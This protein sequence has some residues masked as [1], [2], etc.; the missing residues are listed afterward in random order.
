MP[1]PATHAAVGVLLGAYSRRG[2]LLCLVTTIFAVLPDIDVIL[3]IHR[4]PTHSLIIPAAIACTYLACKRA[5]VL[6]AAAA[7]LSHIFLDMFNSPV[8]VLCP[9][10][11][12]GVQVK[13][14][15][16]VKFSSIPTTWVNVQLILTH[17]VPQTITE[18]ESDISLGTALLAIALAIAITTLAKEPK[19][20]KR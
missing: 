12:I 13:V 8:P 14:E 4:S 15:I 6:Y 17:Y 18:Y 2:A 5:E 16:E 9:L 3:G 19:R 1:D 20:T 11:D 10:T 7:Y